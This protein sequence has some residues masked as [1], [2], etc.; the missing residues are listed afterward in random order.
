MLTRGWFEMAIPNTVKPLYPNVPAAPG[1]PTLAGPVQAQN[2]IVL[3][4]S[5]AYVVSNLLSPPQWGLFT[6]SGA[7]AFGA[8][9]S[10]IA[11]VLNPSQSTQEVEFRQDHRIS[12]APQEQG[13]FLSYNKVSTPWQGK[14]SYVV[15]GTIAQRQ[16]FL[17]QVQ[18]LQTLP[19]GTAALLTLVMPEYTYPSCDIIHHDFRREAH[20][21]VSMFIVDVWV[22]QVRVSGTAAYSNTQNPASA[23][24]T[25]GGTVQPQTPTASQGTVGLTMQIDGD[26]TILSTD[27]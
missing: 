26:T 7:A 24:S 19:A 25:N 10:G 22:E 15:S 16:A 27:K 4:V 18:A 17:A 9:T 14:V 13:A 6:S 20:R 8:V 3:L 23:D 21:G 11:T 1:V 2:N 5:D 12:T